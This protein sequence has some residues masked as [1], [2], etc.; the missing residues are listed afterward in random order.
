MEYVYASLLLHAAKKEIS[1]AA[2]TSVLKSAGISANPAQAKSIVAA[3][4]NVNIEDAIKSA[5]L[6]VA[7]PAA[8]A[9]PSGKEAKKEEKKEEKEEKKEEV[10][11]LGALFG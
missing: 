10:A 7:A 5:A 8:S 3:L 9:A 6:P 1:E 11:G 4:E 2:I